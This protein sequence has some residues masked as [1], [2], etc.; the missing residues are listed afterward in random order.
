MMPEHMELADEEP[1]WSNPVEGMTPY[2]EYLGFRCAG[3]GLRPD[4]T[5]DGNWHGV[6]CHMGT[7][8]PSHPQWPA[9]VASEFYKIMYE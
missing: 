4:T 2:G 1:T 6:Q 5:V 9:C 3:D 7:G 8:W